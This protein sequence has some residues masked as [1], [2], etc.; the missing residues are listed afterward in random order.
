MVKKQTVPKKTAPK[1][2][3]SS[4]K[5]QTKSQQERKK[6]KSTIIVFSIL[7][8]L[9]VILLVYFVTTMAPTTPEQNPVAVLETSQGTIKIELFK[10]QM[11][12][13]AGNFEK[14]VR[15]G[16]YDETKFHRV[17][18]NFM[19]QGG[20]PKTKDDSL[21]NEWGTGDPGYKIEDEFV[22]GLSNARGTISMANSGRPNTGGSQFFI[23]VADNTFLDFDKEPLQSKHPVFGQVVGGMGVVDAIVTAPN[24][25]APFNRPVEDVII[26]KAYI[27]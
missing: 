16:F 19:I 9:A 6:K 8:A 14:L 25:G 1:K 4:P 10:D 23:N 12:I 15:D 18:E 20:D 7:A 27:E 2:A 22:E 17:I 26:T 21:A 13:T 5:K 3:A 24:T 11:P